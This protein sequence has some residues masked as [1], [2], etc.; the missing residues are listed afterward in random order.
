MCSALLAVSRSAGPVALVASVLTLA[1]S[2]GCTA[3]PPVPAPVPPPPVAAGRFATV[4][5]CG[6]MSGTC[7][8]GDAAQA[9]GA[10]DGQYVDLSYCETLDLTFTGGTITPV[11][12]EPD[13]ALHTGLLASGL[14]V[15]MSN[16]GIAYVLGAVV[17]LAGSYVPEKQIIVEDQCKA[18][19]VPSTHGRRALLHL[20]R[21]HTV[22]NIRYVRVTRTN[23]LDTSLQIDAVEALEGSFEPNGDGGM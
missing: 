3:E 18:E 7:E 17:D 20:D 4:A 8:V 1:A 12:D 6:C 13:L 5:T 23:T 15:E 2:S 14:W 11:V 10:P 19:T 16:D 22:A 9:Q 21:C